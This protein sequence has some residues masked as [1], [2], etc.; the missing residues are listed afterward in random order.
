MVLTA[1]INNA[2]GGET[3]KFIIYYSECGNIG[4]ELC[5]GILN[6]GNNTITC[7][8]SNYNQDCN[9]IIVLEVRQEGILCKEYFF[10][11][12][13]N[14]VDNDAYWTCSPVGDSMGCIAHTG[15]PTNSDFFNTLEECNGTCNGSY[16]PCSECTYI[17]SYNC[18]TNTL[19]INSNGLCQCET[20]NSVT[21]GGQV[22]SVGNMICYGQTL[23]ISNV[24]LPAG[25]YNIIITLSI[26]NSDGEVCAYN[27]VLTVFC[28]NGNTDIQ[29]CEDVS[30]QEGISNFIGSRRC[31]I[32]DVTDFT[33]D[34]VL[35]FGNNTVADRYEVY[36]NVQNCNELNSNDLIASTPWVGVPPTNQPGYIYECLNQGLTPFKPGFWEGTGIYTL[37][38]DGTSDGYFMPSDFSPYLLGNLDTHSGACSSPVRNIGNGGHIYGKGRLIIPQASFSG[39]SNVT[40]V[41]YG[42]PTIEPCIQNGITH[43]NCTASAFSI[44]CANCC[45]CEDNGNTS[46]IS[47]VLSISTSIDL[48]LRT[49]Q[50]FPVSPGTQLA[51]YSEL[52]VNVPALNV[53]NDNSAAIIVDYSGSYDRAIY[54]HTRPIKSGFFTFDTNLVKADGTYFKCAG[55]LTFGA[56][57]SSV[58][59]SI[60]GPYELIINNCGVFLKQTIIDPTGSISNAT[61][62]ISIE[63]TNS[64]GTH[65]CILTPPINTREFDI[66]IPLVNGI[67]HVKASSNM[68]INLG[69]LVTDDTNNIFVNAPFT[70]P[71]S[72]EF[73]LNF[74]SCNW[75]NT[76]YEDI[77]AQA[78]SL[79]QNQF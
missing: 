62:D 29:C 21:I 36:K 61:S 1:Q 69:V 45:N 48:E 57:E 35:D 47:D 63:F 68:L 37:A 60:K 50:I 32:L 40:I 20:I 9:E 6:A 74:E 76:N 64:T 65:T 70:I 38:N 52:I 72:L 4:T 44:N 73:S 56:S 16:I 23:N 46:N 66:I 67:N 78:C 26:T 15:L 54:E 41:A 59:Y 10:N 19:S 22:F 49:E 75:H 17:P 42:N 12:E 33:S 18:T 11:L 77:V 71:I 8:Y 24:N 30:I 7:D 58:I 27:T 14:T 79:M 51:E 39:E 53:V 43:N 3:Y 31:Y 55:G 34:L 13:N 25:S 5:I 28:G 2:V